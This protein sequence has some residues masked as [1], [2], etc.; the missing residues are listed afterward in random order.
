MSPMGKKKIAKQIPQHVKS[1]SRCPA[2]QEQNKNSV[3]FTHDY[4][5]ASIIFLNQLKRDSINIQRE[6]KER[7][8]ER[9]EK[10][11]IRERERERKEKESIRE[12]E[13]EGEY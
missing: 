6:R 5:Y 1:S 3:N 13:R 7:E 9:K 10:E 8:R 2:C 4:F 12:R 11:S